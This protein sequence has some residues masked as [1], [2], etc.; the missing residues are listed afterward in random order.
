MH[1]CLLFGPL[2]FFA[3]PPDILVEDASGQKT[4]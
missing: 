3:L 2:V 4:V 1:L